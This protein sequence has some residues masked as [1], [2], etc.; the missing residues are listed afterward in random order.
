MKIYRSKDRRPGGSRDAAAALDKHGIYV[1]DGNYYALGVTERLGLEGK[2]G[3]VRVG[4]LMAL[5][6][7][8]GRLGGDAAALLAEFG[9]EPM[10]FDDPENTLDMEMVGRILGRCIRR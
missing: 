5:P 7:T 1:W 9:L 8:L 2:G 4:P 6:A 3:M 10:F